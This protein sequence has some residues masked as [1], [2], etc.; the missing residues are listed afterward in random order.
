[1]LAI[2][3]PNINQKNHLF[4]CVILNS[5]NFAGKSEKEIQSV[6]TEP[7]ES[8]SNPNIASIIKFNSYLPQDI[9][10]LPSLQCEVFDYILNGIINQHLG[11]FELN[12]AKIIE[13]TKIGIKTDLETIKNAALMRNSAFKKAFNAKM[14]NNN[15]K[16]D[17]N[18]ISAYD[19]NRI[20]HPLSEQAKLE[21]IDEK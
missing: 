12:I 7:K 15:S 9:E 13:D 20:K 14:G 18:D 4:D 3:P 19:S 11:V 21:E 10:F 2:F 6:K 5:L 8:G 17:S 16:D 1:M